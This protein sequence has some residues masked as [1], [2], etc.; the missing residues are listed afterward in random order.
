MIFFPISV[1][2]NHTVVCGTS[3]GSTLFVGS[4][5]ETKSVDIIAGK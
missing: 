3:I 1:D 5:V 2:R 4:R